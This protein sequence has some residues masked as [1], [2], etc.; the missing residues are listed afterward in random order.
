MAILQAGL[1]IAVGLANIDDPSAL[2]RNL[3]Y[4]RCS[5]KFAVRFIV[6]IVCAIVPLVAFVVPL[7]VEI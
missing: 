5:I 6:M 2:V 1:G 7:A 3:S 4:S